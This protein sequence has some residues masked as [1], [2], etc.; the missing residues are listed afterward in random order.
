MPETNTT[1]GRLIKGFPT[2]QAQMAEWQKKYTYDKATG[3]WYE[4]A[5][6]EPTVAPTTPAKTELPF[7]QTQAQM[8]EYQQKYTFTG[9]KWYE[10]APTAPVTPTIPTVPITPTI[11][12]VPITPTI[13]TVPITP[14]IPV[15]EIIPTDIT[16]PELPPAVDYS[17]YFGG[18]AN[19]VANAR[20]TLEKAYTD[21]IATLQTQQEASQKKIDSLLAQQKDIL[22]TDIQSL[23]QPWREDMEKSERERLKV[24]ENYFANQNSVKE[25]EDLLNRSLSDIQA[26]ESITGLS[27]IRSPRIAKIKE[28]YTAR[29]GIIEAVM[30]TRNNQISVATNLIDRSINAIIGDKNAQLKYYQSLY[31]FYETQRDEEGNR[32]ISLEQTERSYINAQIGLL[33]N[34]LEQAQTTANYIKGLMLDPATASAMEGAGVTLSDTPQQIQAKLAAYSYS[35]EI[36]DT[37]NTMAA[38]GYKQI[39]EGQVASKPAGEVTTLTDSK[40]VKRYYWKAIPLAEIEGVGIISKAKDYFTDTQIAKG[41]ATAGIPIAEFRELP[42]DEANKYIYEKP[43]PKP[44]ETLYGEYAYWYHPITMQ[45]FRGNQPAPI[46]GVDWIKIGEV[47]EAP[48][49]GVT[50]GLP[51]GTEMENLLFGVE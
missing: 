43:L 1:K 51:S 25:L 32:L 40:G 15:T 30:A 37:S 5:V 49:E 7:P 48:M 2:T 27:S 10:K 6:V 42:I 14:T 23:L 19:E 12:T 13:P 21:Q 45:G 38:N 22:E 35:Q 17:A 26:A 3:A 39:L 34:D 36:I 9:G 24:E 31:N 18:I 41:A 33:E 16:A 46:D 29:A 50:T 8:A 28:D 44:A 11:P 20:I 4:P 47:P